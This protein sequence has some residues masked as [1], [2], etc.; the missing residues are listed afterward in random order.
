MHKYIVTRIVSGGQTGADRAALDAARGL[1]CPYGGWL[2]AG[3]K[4]EEGPLPPCYQLREI[5]SGSY[6][7]RTEQNVI[8]SD[9]TLIVSHGTLAG[10]SLL[11]RQLA[12]KHGRPH[13]HVDLDTLSPDEALMATAAWIRQKKIGVLNV[14]GP[15]ASGDPA[16]YAAVKSLVTELLRLPVQ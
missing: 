13:L 2:P 10:G 3:R 8:D 5:H 7:E 4:T 1:G 9:G 16:I 14:A 6:R 15:R 11:T 12:Q